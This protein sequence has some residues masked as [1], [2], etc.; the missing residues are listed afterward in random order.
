MSTSVVVVSLAW[1]YVAASISCTSPV[2]G[3]IITRLSVASPVAIPVS[4]SVEAVAVVASSVSIVASVMVVVASVAELVAVRSPTVAVS[5]VAV[6]ANRLVIV[7]VT[8]S[9]TEAN[10]FVVVAFVATRLVAV[11]VPSNVVGPP[12]VLVASTCSSCWI[13]IGVLALKINSTISKVVVAP[14][15]SL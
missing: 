11:V 9:S 13:V 14:V 1:K 2:T 5:I 7:P 12:K 15:S 6:V 10:R 3:S 4:A 8:A